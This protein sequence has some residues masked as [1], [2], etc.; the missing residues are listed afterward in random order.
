MSAYIIVQVDVKDPVRYEDYKRLVPASLAKYGG[1]FVVRGGRTETL[2][3][4]WSPKRVVMVEFPDVERAKA[5]W[6]SADYAEAKALRQATSRTEMIVV[7]G[8]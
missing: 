3:G 1:R 6:A 2:E 4:T 8:V 7:E 5:W